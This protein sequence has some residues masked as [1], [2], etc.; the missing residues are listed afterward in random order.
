MLFVAAVAGVALVD[1]LGR[2]AAA[3]LGRDPDELETAAA[4]VVPSGGQGYD[5]FVV[6]VELPVAL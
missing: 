4:A 2:S 5:P 6:V 1:D 3:V